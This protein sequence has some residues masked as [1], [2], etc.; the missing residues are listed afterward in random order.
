MTAVLAPIEA[1]RGGCVKQLLLDGISVHHVDVQIFNAGREVLPGE[2]P[3]AGP[4]DAAVLDSE[5][6]VFGVIRIHVDILHV[7]FLGV[8]AREEPLCR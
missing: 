8:F 3:V 2:A 6:D 1:P 5:H 4:H 7:A